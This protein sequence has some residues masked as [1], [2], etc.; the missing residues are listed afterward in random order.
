MD[1]GEKIVLF[2]VIFI[3]DI[4]VINEL[5]SKINQDIK[6]VDTQTWMV[7]E[8]YKI[9]EIKIKR[10][11]GFFNDFTN[12]VQ[13]ENLNFDERRSNFQGRVH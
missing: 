5:P 10:Q 11:I 4:N 2:G 7:Y 3:D 12:Y 1:D 13:R 9:N 8:H 6:F